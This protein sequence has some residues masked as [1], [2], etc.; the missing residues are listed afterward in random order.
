M[1]HVKMLALAAVAAASLMALVGAG[2]ASA[3]V[4]CSTT[5]TPCTSVVANG[6]VF[7]FSS[8]EAVL[9]DTFGFVRNKCGSTL[10][11]TLDNGSSTATA[12]LTA[13][14]LTWTGCT[15]TPAVTTL[16]G[17]LEIHNIAGTSN[18]TV[19]ANGFKVTNP[20]FGNDC[21]YETGSGLDLGT[22]TE[23]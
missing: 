14:E 20:I 13:T 5:T 23:G 17:N 19:T 4:V 16:L 11:G 6:T 15:I 8:N 2:T 7:D 21:I 3:S 22:L 18:G 1:K 9:S 12:K 10:K